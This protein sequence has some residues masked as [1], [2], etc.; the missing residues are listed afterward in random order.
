MGFIAKVKSYLH[1][2]RSI[3]ESV[4]LICESEISN[5]C[6]KLNY[7]RKVS[8]L[9]NYALSSGV[10]GVSTERH[11]EEEIIVSLTTHKKRISEVYLAIESIMQGSLKPNRIV[12]W[13]SNEYKGKPL[14][15]TLQKQMKRGLEVVYCRDIRSY[16]KLVPALKA[17]PNASIVTI[18]DDIIYPYDLLENLVNAHIEEPYAICATWIHDTPMDLGDKYVSLLDWPMLYD[19]DK[20][21][22]RYFFEGFGGVLY[23]PSCLDKEVFN[24][25]VFLD[26]CKH[27]DDVWFNAMALKAGTKIKYAWEHFGLVPL[28]GNHNVQSVALRDVNS[29]GEI[30]NDVQIKAVYGKYGL[31]EVLRT[32]V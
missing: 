23:P 14:P 28:V 29:K 9:T 8:E 22:C 19:V 6:A 7:D 12:L 24:E 15:I 4:K 3:V 10:S 5:S 26:I 18:D 13:I 31:F 20:A 32:Q 30:L 21:S 2:Q 16:T 27:A 25:E 1:L 17:Y 11:A